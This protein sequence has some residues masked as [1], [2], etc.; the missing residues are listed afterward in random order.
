ML[1]LLNYS[2]I[3]GRE[4][5]RDRK[6]EERMKRNLDGEEEGGV[7]WGRHEV[8]S[9]A[10]SN[11]ERKKLR[12]EEYI[13]RLVLTDTYHP[14]LLSST[15]RSLKDVT[16]FLLICAMNDEGMA[17]GS[18]LDVLQLAIDERDCVQGH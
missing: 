13:S 14:L 17:S 7:F 12:K 15:R 8:E 5:E 1:E 3:G 2:D 16:R 18:G 11:A 9:K 4:T 10:Q 6:D